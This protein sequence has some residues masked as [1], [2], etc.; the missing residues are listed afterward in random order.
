MSETF[1]GTYTSGA[2]K[3]DAEL[4]LPEGARVVCRVEAV[5]DKSA[6]AP[7]PEMYIHDDEQGWIRV[8]REDFG[9][10]TDSQKRAARELRELAAASK[11]NLRGWKFNREEAHERR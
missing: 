5:G 8:R 10:L 1:V 3:P 9:G 6:S 4:H 2:I 11:L 7:E